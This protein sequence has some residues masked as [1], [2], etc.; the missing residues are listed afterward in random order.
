MAGFIYDY[1]GEFIP[2]LM[3]GD[4]YSACAKN[5]DNID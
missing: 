2:T 4:C 5:G 1:G 3:K